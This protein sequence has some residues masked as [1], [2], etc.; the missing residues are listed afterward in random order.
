MNPSGFA[1]PVV[2]RHAFDQAMLDL[3]RGRP[4]VAPAPAQALQALC[5]QA[6][7]EQAN[8]PDDQLKFWAIAS[9][10]FAHLS[11]APAA[12]WQDWHS[13]VCGRI[14]AAVPGLVPL[15]PTPTQQ[16]EAL[17]G[18]FLEFVHA[19]VE[20]WQALLQHWAT[21]PMEEASANALLNATDHMQMLLRDMQL[22]GMADLCEALALAVQAALAR[23][24]L[25][26]LADQALPAAHEMLRLL[27]QFAAGF[28]REPNPALMA[29]LR[30]M[31][32]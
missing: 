26:G 1:A 18:L 12:A 10:F 13:V 19:Q 3:L 11:L 16:A 32:A 29:A 6:V 15:A 20:H 9:H 27:H 31:A 14:M 7:H 25:S 4:Q 24:D 28:V 22:D 2:W 23:E 21:A 17:N 5:V 30:D 8:A